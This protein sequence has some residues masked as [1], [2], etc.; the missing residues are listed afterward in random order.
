MQIREIQI[1]D[2]IQIKELHKK[3]NL[4]ILDKDE[5]IEFWKKNPCILNSDISIPPECVQSN[6]KISTDLLSIIISYS[7][8]PL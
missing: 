7:E 8:I 1:E 5:W 3:Y 4:N 2:Y 6:C